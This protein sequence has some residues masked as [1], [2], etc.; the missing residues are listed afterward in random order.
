MIASY[1][2]PIPYCAFSLGSFAPHLLSQFENS[3]RKHNHV[4]LM[5]ALLI[6]LAKAGRLSPAQEKARQLMKERI[7]KRRAKGDRGMD[8]D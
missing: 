5:H 6:A 8:E 3:L 4:G 2:L 1:E 7:E